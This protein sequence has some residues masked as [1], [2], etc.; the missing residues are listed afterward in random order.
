[1][2]TPTG[3]R[4]PESFVQQAT[5][6]PHWESSGLGLPDLSLGPAS[7]LAW[8]LQETGSIQPLCLS[9]FRC[10]FAKSGRDLKLLEK[11]TK[12]VCLCPI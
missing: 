2:A 1:M 7:A 3:E 6:G 4:G 11:K 8:D 9:S 12:K 5:R 10:V